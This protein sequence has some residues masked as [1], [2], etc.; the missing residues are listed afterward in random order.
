MI[1][2]FMEQGVIALGAADNDICMFRFM[3]YRFWSD[4]I[5]YLSP[6]LRVKPTVWSK[7]MGVNTFIEPIRDEVV[8][9]KQLWLDVMQQFHDIKDVLSLQSTKQLFHYTTYN[10][11]NINNVSSNTIYDDTN[12]YVLMLIKKYPYLAEPYIILSASLKNDEKIEVE[13]YIMLR[14]YHFIIKSI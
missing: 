2:D 5:L 8:K 11:I 3:R 7:Y 12:Q 1:A 4:F 14:L 13:E 10:T 9:L 6:Y